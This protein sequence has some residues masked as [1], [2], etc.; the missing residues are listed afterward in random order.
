MFSGGCE[1]SNAIMGFDR[2]VTTRVMYMRRCDL[3]NRPRINIYKGVYKQRIDIIFI[4]I[5]KKI[6][7]PLIVLYCMYEKLSH[8]MSKVSVRNFTLNKIKVCDQYSNL[9]IIASI[10]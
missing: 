3:C 6:L 7:D 10:T 1:S 2:N 5:R 9:R 8:S 4:L